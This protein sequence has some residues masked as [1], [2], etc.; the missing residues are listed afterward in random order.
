MS[1]ISC[2]TGEAWEF[3]CNLSLVVI[4]VSRG[5]GRRLERQDEGSSIDFFKLA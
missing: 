3:I 5:L 2:T 1:D 4:E